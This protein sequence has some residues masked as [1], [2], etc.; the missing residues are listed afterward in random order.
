[1]N[2]VTRLADFD[3]PTFDPFIADELMF[4]ECLDPYPKL[5]ELRAK[6]PVHKLDYR[7]F[8]GEPADAHELAPAALRRRRLRR[9]RALPDRAREFLER[10]LQAQPRHQLRPQRQHDGPA[11]ASALPPDFPEGVPA[12]DGGEVGRV[13]RRPGRQRADGEIPAPRLG[14][15][16][17][18]IHAALPVPD[19][20]PATGVAARGGSTFHKLAIA[21]TVVSYDVPHGTEASRKLGVYFKDLLDEETPPSRH[22]PR[23]RAGAGRSGRREAAGGDPDF[24]PAPARQ[25]RRRHDLP[26]HQRPADRAAV[27]PRPARSRAQGPIAGATGHR[28]S[29]ALG[30]PG[31]DPDAHGGQ[32][33][34][35]R[36]HDDSAR[37]P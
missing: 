34:R 17:P 22:G 11:G 29:A 13:G 33:R 37:A 9:S 6:G 35:T 32:G 24:I 16:R 1:M 25:C 27:E 31:A 10:G 5:A 2:A 19:R 21:Q 28:G 18:G 20:L 30:R 4:G 26:W 36:R 12:A 8:M 15:P 7:V 14:R 3:D 23:E